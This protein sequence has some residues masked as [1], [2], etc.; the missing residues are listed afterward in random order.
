MNVKRFK[1]MHTLELERNQISQQFPE[2]IATMYSLRVLTLS[3]NDILGPLP[4]KISRL[5]LMEI[6]DVA[7]N[8][9]LNGEIAEHVL[10][11]WTENEYISIMNTSLSG[12]IN[13]LCSDV[14]YCWRFMYDTHK[15]LTWATAADVPDIVNVTMKLAMEHR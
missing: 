3:Y 10:A 14:P 6:F 4:E 2:D 5:R 7:H 1:F 9:R 11:E 13:G 12:Y 15:D 8:P